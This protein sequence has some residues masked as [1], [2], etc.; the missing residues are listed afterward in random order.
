MTEDE[1][2][3]DWVRIGQLGTRSDFAESDDDIPF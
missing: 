1:W 2:D 3:D